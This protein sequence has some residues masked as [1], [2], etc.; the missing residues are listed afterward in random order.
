MGFQS[1]IIHKNPKGDM[2]QPLTKNWSFSAPVS[3]SA[4]HGHAVGSIRNKALSPAAAPNDEA[5][6]SDG[7]SMLACP[8]SASSFWGTFFPW[9]CHGLEEKCPLRG[10][11]SPI[12]QQTHIITN[13]IN[14]WSKGCPET[15]GA[16]G[17]HGTHWERTGTA[18]GAQASRLRFTRQARCLHLHKD[19]SP[20]TRLKCSRHFQEVV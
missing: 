16:C 13:L 6:I 11:R 2:I 3:H 9:R 18:L 1:P 20:S 7:P 10:A 19:P 8:F 5:T 15:H 12:I 4:A 14:N 17:A